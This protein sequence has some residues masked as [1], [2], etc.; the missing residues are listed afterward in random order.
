MNT[1]YK[2]KCIKCGIER[3]MKRRYAR[4]CCRYC[5]NLGH[6]NHSKPHSDETK[7][8][9]SE[10]NRLKPTLGFLGKR[11]SNYTKDKL[12]TYV[13][14]N[15]S[16]YGKDHSKIGMFG[17]KQSDNQKRKMREF[18]RNKISKLGTISTDFGQLEFLDKWNKLGFNF[19]PNYQIYT[20]DFLC[21]LDGYDKDK[22]VVV[23][24]DSKYHNSRKQREKD[25][26][27]QNKII[28]I[29]K[30]KKFWRYNSENKQ[31]KN[32]LER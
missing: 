29:L 30:P 20:K 32:V 18:T 19:Q 21:Y 26:I 28:D 6:K 15:N 4:P 9:L 24:Y 25:L 12:K 27:R 11:H 10:I 2:H 17:K 22:N 7:R 1:I 3:E 16:Q 23:E 8:K 13:G 14:E 31:I 5:G